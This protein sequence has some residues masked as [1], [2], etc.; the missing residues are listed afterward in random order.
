ML[1]SK[2]GI[3]YDLTSDSKYSVSK[4]TK[5]LL[6]GLKD[7]ITIYYMVQQGHEV[8]EFEKIAKQYDKLSS[9]V[10]LV[11][12]DPILYPTFGSKYV[13]DQVNDNSFIVVNNTTNKAKYI[14][15][16]DML[17]KEMDYQTY[18]EKTTG[19]DAEGKL[20]AAVLYVTS[21]K[22]PNMYVVQGHGEPAIV[23]SF[24]DA[25]S[26]MNVNVKTF[27]TISETSIPQDCDILYIN[28]PKTDFT[29]GETTM[30]KDY[31]AA[32]GKAIITGNYQSEPLKNF[33]SILDY[34]GIKM[35]PGLVLEGDKNM[36]ESNYPNRL[37]PKVEFHDISNKARDNGGIPVYM[38]NASGLLVSDTKRSSLNIEPLLSTSSSAYSKVDLQSDVMDKENTD[39]NGPFY[40]GLA[41]TDTYK[42]VTTKLVVFSSE[43]TFSDQTLKLGNNDV[44]SGTISYL[45]GNTSTLSIPAKKYGE[46]Y[47]YAS[48]TQDAIWGAVT[49]LVIPLII[50]VTGAVVCLRRRKK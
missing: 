27:N 15:G 13:Q 31:L 47:I 45:T 43:L 33:T 26:K 30:I 5:D 14:D 35:V 22:L 38:P 28:A 23:K 46:N 36:M 12:K 10:T 37:L 29:D 2:M 32:G 44:L 11:N 49:I 24:N 41:S 9:H 8:D 34:Y 39:I 21:E 16:Q 3:Q 17:V 40:L 42:N 25:M 19:T 48:V 20:T 18:Q 6:A 1:V 4:E 50:F 7:D